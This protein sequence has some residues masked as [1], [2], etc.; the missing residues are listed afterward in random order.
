MNKFVPMFLLGTLLCFQ[1]CSRKV[2]QEIARDR[3]LTLAG[4]FLRIVS[5]ALSK[6]PLTMLN[7]EPS[8]S[9]TTGALKIC[10]VRMI[11]L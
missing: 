5:M 6:P 8:T 1:G 9:L 11:L 10:L 3:N 4:N 2:S 7:G